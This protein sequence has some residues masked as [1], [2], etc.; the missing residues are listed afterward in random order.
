MKLPELPVSYMNL[1]LPKTS[2]KCETLT[3]HLNI[4]SLSSG[5]KVRGIFTKSLIKE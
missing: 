4:N 3:R 5:I 1:T 2:W